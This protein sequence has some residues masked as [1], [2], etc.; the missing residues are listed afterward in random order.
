[1]SCTRPTATQFY[2]GENRGDACAFAHALI[3]AG[4]SIV[5]GSGPTA[6][7]TIERYRGRLIAC[8]L[9]N[10]SATTRSAAAAYLT[11]ARPCG[12]AS[13]GPPG[14][15]RR[16]DPDHAHRRAAASQSHGRQRQSRQDPLRTG[17]PDRPPEDP[18]RRCVPGPG[19]GRQPVALAARRSLSIPCRPERE[20]CRFGPWANSPEP[21]I[22]PSGPRAS[23]RAAGNHR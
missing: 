13:P 1:M 21:Q 22:T 11:T 6:F 23:G 20:Q 7:R 2:L 19:R 8:S 10:S 18:L 14:A 17:L 15:G 12:D 4:A 3:D 16:V 9:G 5:L